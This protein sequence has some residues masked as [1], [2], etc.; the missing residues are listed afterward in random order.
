MD[1]TKTNWTLPKLLVL[2]QNY[3]DGSKSFWTH[4]R[5]RHNMSIKLYLLLFLHLMF[6]LLYQQVVFTVTKAKKLPLM[7]RI[8]NVDIVYFFV[9]CD[10]LILGVGKSR[11]QFFL[12]INP[13]NK[14][15]ILLNTVLK[16]V[17]DFKKYVSKEVKL[18]LQ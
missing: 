17:F 4:R 1:P 18:C 8:C 13:K 12:S 16:T 3:L 5:T 6:T 14:Q 11:N 10:W 15:K 2:D 9:T 7:S